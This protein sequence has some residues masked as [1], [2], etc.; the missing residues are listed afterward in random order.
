MKIYIESYGCTLNHGEARYLKHLL[1]NAGHSFDENIEQANVIVLFTCCVIETTEL[2]MI[3]RARYFSEFDKPLIVS[4]CMAVVRRE[5]L[6]EVHPDVYFLEPKEIMNIND[7][8]D[9]ISN[10]T[11]L[12]ITPKEEIGKIEKREFS[13][14][15]TSTSDTEDLAG[16]Y[17]EE[18]GESI[19][20]IIPIATGCRGQCNYCITRLARGKLKSY[21]LES[22]LEDAKSAV[23]AG[24]YELRLTAQD[25]AC[26]GY[27]TQ[28][29]LAELLDQLVTINSKHEFRVRVGMMNPD[30]II[31]IQNELI[32]CYKHPRIF[33]FL[34]I[35]VQSG[36]DALLN[37]MGRKYTV[38]EF[39]S[40]T[41]Q[42]RGE[43]PKVTISTD[44]I[45][46]YPN[47]TDEQFQNSMDLLHRLKPNIVN[48][49]R[50]SSRPGTPAA[51][52]KNKL[53]GSTIKKRSRE[54]T[55]LRFKLSRELNEQE[56]GR[57][58]QIL[59]TERVK[60]GS[61]LG[62][63]DYYQP[64]VVKKALQLGSWVDVT[65]TE[66]ADAYLIGEV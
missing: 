55:A 48:I 21:S 45:V 29:N 9:E 23:V 44:I 36:D 10:R 11:D 33:K 30:S 42:F 47:E 61:V 7:L 57:Q 64:V 53:T 54:M 31:S 20:S 19:D 60:V 52:L 63:T 13:K 17:E 62:R 40:I 8:I 15:L 27:D 50:F 56:I 41:D 38:S 34:H 16:E 39:L 46:G 1:I 58:Y 66:A 59:I 3:K 5:A 51:M 65:V 2:K 24:H 4:G 25:T 12:S 37:A 32:D 35:P 26:Y 28:K 22:I 43:I 6:S 49:T 14:P 18:A